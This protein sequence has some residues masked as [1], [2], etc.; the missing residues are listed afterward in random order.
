MKKNRSTSIPGKLQSLPLG[1]SPRNQST[2]KKNQ[3]VSLSLK[4]PEIISLHKENLELR[5]KLKDFN[6]KLNNL[7]ISSKNKLS[8]TSRPETN[9]ELE[10]KHL[11]RNL[12][13]YE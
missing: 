6:E 4:N 11:K 7:I 13:Y 3:F 5:T 10:L 8:S 12:E 9:P 2:T 1:K